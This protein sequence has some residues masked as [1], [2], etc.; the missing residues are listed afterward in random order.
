MSAMRNRAA[1]IVGGLGAFGGFA[2]PLLMGLV[3]KFQ[4]PPGYAQGFFLFS[5]MSVL[6]MLAVARLARNAPAEYRKT[7]QA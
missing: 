6:A 1:G 5:A 7:I 4:G 2:I 3:V